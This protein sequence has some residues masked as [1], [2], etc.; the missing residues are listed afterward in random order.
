MSKTVAIM[1]HG[2][3]GDA[4]TATSVFKYKEE[5]WGEGCKIVWFASAENWDIFKHSDIEVR[6]FPR[7]F[8]YPEMVVEENRKLVEQGKE[9]V[10]EDW[11]P[12]V[13][14]NNHLNLELAK[15]VP[16]LS[17]F[18]IGYLPA[19]HQVPHSKRLNLDY[20]NVSRKVFGIPDNYEWHPVLA[21]SEQERI[22]AKTFMDNLPDGRNIFFETFAGSGQTFLTEEIVER[23]MWICREYWKDCNFIFGSHKYLSGNEQYPQGFFERK[24]VYSCSNFTAR[25]TALISGKCDLILSVSSGLCVA[26]SCWGNNPVPIIQAAGSF[27]CSTQSLAL[28]EF[29]LVTSEH[30]S[31]EKAKDDFY[32][33][34]INHLIKRQ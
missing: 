32:L 12:L 29:E 23:A 34:L 19:P 8:G 10:W 22:D 3:C 11:K 15:N 21:F 17:E 26:A 30:K 7:G 24:G 18:Q 25:Q 20:P 14:E 31:Y 2:Q 5:L 16:S 33:A 27:I 6:E 1:L 4:M 9:P 13:D 28:G